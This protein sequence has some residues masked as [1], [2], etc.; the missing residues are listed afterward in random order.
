MITEKDIIDLLKSINK[1]KAGISSYAYE[2]EN[3]LK[4]GDKSTWLIVSV[5]DYDFYMKDHEFRELINN[6]R[7][8]CQDKLISVYRP[9]NDNVK[10]QLKGKKIIMP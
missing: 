9:L 5:N 6:A 1:L 8:K 10:K 3:T 7:E 2:D 4:N